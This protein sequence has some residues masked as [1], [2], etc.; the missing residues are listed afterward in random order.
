MNVTKSNFLDATAEI[1]RLLPTVEFVAI[2]EEMTGIFLPGL[3]EFVGDAPSARYSKMR[4]V[5][6]NY[7]IIQFGVAL[8]TK[9]AGNDGKFVAHAYNFYTFPETGA[10]N[11]EAS[12][13]H[14]NS[15]NGMDWNSWIREGVPYVTREAAAKLKLQ[16]FPEEN[17]STAAKRIQLTSTFDIEN[18]RKAIESLKGWLADEARQ[19]QKELEIITCNAYLR[20]FMHETLR[21]NFP[22]LAVESRPTKIRGLS[23]MVALRLTAAEKV[24]R[25]AKIR[26]EK[27][28][29][30]TLKVGVRRV[31]EALANSRK[32]II[33]HACLYDLMFAFSHFEGP[34]PESF[35][36]F[37]KSVCDLF[38]SVYDTQLLA[39]SDVLKL[40]SDS[41]ELQQRFKSFAL[42]EVHRVLREE[43]EAERADGK[44]TV[45]ITLAEGHEKYA[46]AASYHEAGFDAY[47]TGCAF[48]YM[49]KHVPAGEGE[50][51][52][53]GRLVMFR[54]FFNVNLQG[55]DE[56]ITDGAYLHTRGLTGRNATEFTE[57]LQGILKKIKAKP[58]EPD[59]EVTLDSSDA[60]QIRWVDD[61]SA[62]AIFPAQSG[63]LV[64]GVCQHVQA[65][66]GH[67]DGLS[68]MP[69][70]EFFQAE[71]QKADLAE[72]LKKKA[73]TTE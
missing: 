1:E 41:G 38:P 44:E 56:L 47:I 19:D 29:E 42:G 72:P 48:A 15:K 26:A 36:D 24:E 9:E 12:S 70:A 17:K 22:D 35:S 50:K 37:K 57:I 61:D 4:Q 20:R 66:G 39:R 7:S 65:A 40:K 5:A 21:E 49:A 28:A 62:F 51:I 11:M 10:V 13:V 14:F 54:N 30:F 2:D 3:Q 71:S 63:D 33:G 34:L 45:E 58:E 31:F 18:T 53:K 32:P 68:F 6:S 46:T 16:L 59:M 43:A 67:V 8:F 52:F 60:F 69:G 23:T 27:E 55:E 64:A 25:D 73:R